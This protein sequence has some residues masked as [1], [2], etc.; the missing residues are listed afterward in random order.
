M[1]IFLTDGDSRAALAVTRSLGSKGHQVY[2]GSESNKSLSSSSKYCHL[3][4][5][6]P[7]PRENPQ[8]YI[9]FLVE[10]VTN[11]SIDFLIP[12][13]DVSLLL[14]S[15]ERVQFPDTCQIPIPSDK[16]ISLAADKKYI[17]ELAESVGMAVPGSF[18]INTYK[19]ILPSIE[20][21]KL[22]YPVVLKPSRSRVKSENGW[23]STRVDYAADSQ[24]LQHKLEQLNPQAYPVILQE[25]VVGVGSGAFYCFNH[26]KCLAK[27]AHTRIREKPPSG[28]VSVVRESRRIDPMVDD[29]SQKLLKKLQW[30]GVAMVE[31]K[32]DQTSGKAYIMEINGRFWGSLQLAI[33][34]GVD[35]PDI[36]ISMDQES[37]KKQH[38]SYRE[39]VRSRWFWGDVDLLLMYLFKPSKNLKLPQGHPGRLKA[40][41]SI[42]LPYRIG[43]RFEILRLSDLRPWL[44][45]SK[46]WLKKNLLSGS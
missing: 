13:T 17:L 36:V 27:F 29:Y 16:A 35:F 34:A 6:Y 3:G 14:I 12:I 24:E 11:N 39:G 19:D 25:R 9:A 26:G 2:A 20:Q 5:A 42:L 31:L 22:D 37:S 41:L 45:E 15:K 7:S 23:I 46:I 44:Y 4:V 1:N 32:I 40:V 30:H 38:D 8:N 21:C 28:G 33:D 43:Q 10:F 18:S